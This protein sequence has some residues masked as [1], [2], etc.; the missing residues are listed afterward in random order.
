MKPGIF[1]LHVRLFNERQNSDAVTSHAIS[2]TRFHSCRRPSFTLHGWIQS[3]AFRGVSFIYA[4]SKVFLTRVIWELSSDL[5]I[6]PLD[7]LYDSRARGWRTVGL[8]FSVLSRTKAKV[9]TTAWLLQP[10]S[11]ACRCEHIS[12]NLVMMR[13][14]AVPYPPFSL[15]GLMR[16]M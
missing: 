2:S 12:L 1:C 16:Q 8:A 5:K 7:R 3:A 4:N 15:G 10:S 6:I 14:L 11:L 13:L 9:S